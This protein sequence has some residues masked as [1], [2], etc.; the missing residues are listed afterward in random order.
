VSALS[1]TCA[2][3]TSVAFCAPRESCVS[4]RSGRKRLAL[5]R[6]LQCWL[7]DRWTSQCISSS[8]EASKAEVEQFMRVYSQ[9][10]CH[11]EPPN[12]TVALQTAHQW[13]DVVFSATKSRWAFSAQEMNAGTAFG[14]MGIAPILLA[15]QEVVWFCFVFFHDDGTMQLDGLWLG[16]SADLI[17][18]HIKDLHVDQCPVVHWSSRGGFSVDDGITFNDY[19]ARWASNPRWTERV[20]SVLFNEREVEQSNIS[21]GLLIFDVSVQLLSQ[22]YM[23]KQPLPCKVN[24]VWLASRHGLAVQCGK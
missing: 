10:G 22:S 24:F 3:N 1:F 11:C 20:P 12:E 4:P 9:G 23:R 18:D 5:P 16:S 13:K 17:P 14:R 15:M 19:V 8:W 7:I 2:C 6:L 21:R